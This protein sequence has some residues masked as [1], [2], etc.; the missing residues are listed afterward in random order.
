MDDPYVFIQ[1]IPLPYKIYIPST[2]GLLTLRTDRHSVYGYIAGL[3]RVKKILK[4]EMLYKA[5]LALRNEMA[6]VIHPV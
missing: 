3:I 1:H 2:L 4:L 5:H 6:V